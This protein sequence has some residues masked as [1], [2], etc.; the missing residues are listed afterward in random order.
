MRFAKRWLREYRADLRRRAKSPD[1]KRH[2]ADFF[3]EYKAMGALHGD[4]WWCELGGACP[5][6]GDGEVD[7]VPFYFRA[8]GRHWS[9]E[10]GLGTDEDGRLTGETIFE[11]GG[12]TVGEYSASWMRAR[13]AAAL[14][15]AS[16]ND[17]RIWRGPPEKTPCRPTP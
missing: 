1:H 6:Q 10:F 16:V 3:A 13:H 11:R 7:G 14:V 12:E 15:R 17:F 9:I 4:A 5:V 2:T 8:R